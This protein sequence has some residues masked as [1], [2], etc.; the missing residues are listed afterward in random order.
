MDKGRISK[1]RAKEVLEENPDMVS[2]MKD[3]YEALIYN[4]LPG[5]FI[6]RLLYFKGGSDDLPE[7]SVPS[8][9]PDY[10]ILRLQA[11]Y[12]HLDYPRLKCRGN[13]IFGLGTTLEAAIEDRVITDGNLIEKIKEFRNKKYNAFVGKGRAWTTSEDIDSINNILNLTIK[14]IAESYFI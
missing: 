8:D 10:S 7:P 4:D 2:V 13:F 9:H 3:Y 1:E 6:R 14:S 12:N 11:G 5:Y